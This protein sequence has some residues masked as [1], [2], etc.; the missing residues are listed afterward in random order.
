MKHDKRLTEAEL[1][2]AEYYAIAFGLMLLPLSL[3][4]EV[5]KILH[6]ALWPIERR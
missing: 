6:R 4:I 3:L 2:A 1:R 5:A